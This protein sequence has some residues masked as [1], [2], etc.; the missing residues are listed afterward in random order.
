M[1]RFVHTLVLIAVAALL[2]R[3]AGLSHPALLRQR[4][5]FTPGQADIA[6]NM[7]PMVAFVTVALGG[8]RGLIAD[9]LWM[10]ATRMQEEG[11][12]FELVQLA[13]WITTLEPRFTK[14]WGWHA[15]NLAY[16][17]SVLMN[18]PEERWRW[19]Q[20]GIRMLRDEAI[21]YNPGDAELYWELGWMYQ[22]KL[23]MSLD[24]AHLYYK[25]AL[26]HQM[27]EVFDGRIPDFDELEAL[28]EDRAAMQ[29]L[30]GVAD[31]VAYLTERGLDPWDLN[32]YL[33]PDP[34]TATWLAEA[35]GSRPLLQFTRRERLRKAH[36]LDPAIMREVDARYGPLDFRLPD[37]HAIYWAYRGLPHAHDFAEVKLFRMIQHGI[38][39]AF[40]QGRALITL[41]GQLLPSPNTALLPRVRT[42]AREAVDQF[43][44]RATFQTAHENFLTEAFAILLEM[45][46]AD[47]AREV[48]Q[49]LH[50]SYPS[51]QTARGFEYFAASTF[52]GALEDLSYRQAQAMVE[53]AIA[54]S[55]F[56][57]A[58]GDQER[59]EGFEAQ[60][61][62][63]WQQYDLNL[64]T[65]EK[66]E[67]QALPPLVELRRQAM[68]RLLQDTTDPALRRRLQTLATPSTVPEP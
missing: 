50:E 62:R 67:R 20:Q 26:A 60:A 19:V 15:W 39:S 30:P 18:D 5:A 63:I 8:F 64:G 66:R 47:E 41:D 45:G 35:E 68:E 48:Y 22:H 25:N 31:V 17:V 29:A 32:T 55:F 43:P 49:E 46:H 12:Y 27:M 58:M 44:D 6:E 1:R 9:A 14:V 53:G 2:F 42:I 59:F 37:A 38:V 3:Q 54:Q 65:G 33:N 28:P 23:G 11:R 40:R 57:Y 56:W 21:P 4:E 52:A 51:E 10:R 24:Q 13:D 7:P 34:D 61:R 16:N 36:R